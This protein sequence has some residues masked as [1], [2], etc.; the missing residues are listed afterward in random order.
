MGDRQGYLEFRHC[1]CSGDVDDSR[2]ATKKRQ[3]LGPWRFFVVP[4]RNLLVAVITFVEV[5]CFVLRSLPVY[6]SSL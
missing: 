4:A 3:G 2:Q 5:P 6:S 1:A